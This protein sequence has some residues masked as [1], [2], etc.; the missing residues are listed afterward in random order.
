MKK[1]LY[2]F[3][4][5]AT[6]TAFGVGMEDEAAAETYKVENGDSLWKIANKHNVTVDHLKKLNNLTSELIYPNQVLSVKG[7]A[8]APVQNNTPAPAPVRQSG[9]TYTVKSG[10]TL[11]AIA[12]KAGMSFQDLMK[13]NNL[14]SHIIFPGQVLSIKK[15]APGNAGSSPQTPIATKPKES[16]YTVQPGDSLSKIAINH[17]ITLAKLMD[18]NNLSGSLIYAGQKLKIAA[19]ASVNNPPVTA[20]SAPPIQSTVEYIVKSG[21]TLS[22]IALS[23]KISLAE[24]KTINGLTSD[25]IFVGQKLK[26][27]GNSPG[28]PEQISNPAVPIQ[29]AASLLKEASALLNVPY[30][31]GGSSPDG[32]D[33]SGFIYYVFQKAGFSVTRTNA[34]GMHARS[35]EVSAPQPGDLVFFENTY[36]S[37]ISHVGIYLGNDQFI[38]A[39]DKGVEITNL[40]HSYWSTKFES[41]KRFYN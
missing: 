16:I 18:L 7:A 4:T 23:H 38:H 3:A 22:K 28:A 8:A 35:F 12:S 37:G 10:D 33:C 27:K 39:S 1:W 41:F 26:L 5:T 34:V 15:G 6:V 21:D 2:A 30:A 32:F 13:S 29:G 36:R 40:S 24:L 14:S 20:P 9:S 19:D 17:N 25:I 31:W 11:S